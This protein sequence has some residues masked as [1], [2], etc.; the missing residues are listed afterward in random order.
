M[1]TIRSIL[2][3][4]DAGPHSAARLQCARQLGGQLGATVTALYAVTP[5]YV[6]LALNVA[7]GGASD[8]LMAIDEQRLATARRLVADVNAG[9]GLQIEW[10]QARDA[11]EY[12]FIQQALYADLLVVGQHDRLQRDT[13]VLPDFVPSVVI[14]SGKPA[15][16]VPYIGMPSSLDTVFVAWKETPQAAHALSAALPLLRTASA[17]H[18]GIDAALSSE[19]KAAL[20]GFLLR[21]SVVDPQLHTLVATAPDAGAL[22]LSMAADVDA[23]LMVMG[24]YGHSRARELVLGGASRS[25]L[26]SMTLPVLMAH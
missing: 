13:G 15:L 8:V 6:E 18:I 9:P 2:V 23:D 25:V 5:V 4:V 21:H 26:S 14:A 19:S 22:M 24:C 10:Q 11:P 1:S 12:A 3:H 16:V 20:Q 7:A 17:V